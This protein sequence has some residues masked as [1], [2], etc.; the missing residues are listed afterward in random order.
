MRGGKTQTAPLVLR[1]IFLHQ[2]TMKQIRFR[3]T[4]ALLARLKR[5]SSLRAT[6][7]GG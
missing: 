3:L 6:L 2:L 7:E 5:L 1:T 4:P